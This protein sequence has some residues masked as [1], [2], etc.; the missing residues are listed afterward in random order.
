MTDTNLTIQNMRM[1]LEQHF[2]GSIEINDDSHLHVGHAN[3]GAG[4]YTVHIVD[5]KFVELSRVHRHRLIYTI[6]ESCMQNIHALALKLYTPYEY[7]KQNNN[8]E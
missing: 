1:L 4:H 8:D 7:F 5:E 3:Y 6:L 2:T